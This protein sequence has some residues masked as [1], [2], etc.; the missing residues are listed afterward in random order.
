MNRALKLLTNYMSN[1]ILPL[2]D[3]TLQ[4]LKQSHPEFRKPPPELLIEGPLM[5]IYLIVFDDID[6]SFILKA[7]ILTKGGSGLSGLDSDG[8]HRLLTS[9]K[10]ETSST[11][12]RKTFAQL[13]KR[14]CI[15][16][17]K[18]TTSLA[19]FRASRLIYLQIKNLDCDQPVW[20]KF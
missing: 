14:I 13:I 12:L 4:L 9:T 16:E 7:A 6:V 8:L 2:T 10:F 5:E 17:L 11:D 19:A 18:A 15:E 20:L 3:A 1:G